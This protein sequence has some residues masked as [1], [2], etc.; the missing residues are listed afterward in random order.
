MTF[1][2]LTI[3]DLAKNSNREETYFTEYANVTLSQATLLFRLATCLTEL[4]QDSNLQELAKN[5]ILELAFKF[6]ET[7][8]HSDS[9]FS[10][11]TSETIG[12][13]TYN[14]SLAKLNSGETLGSPWFDLAVSELG[15]CDV[16]GGTHGTGGIEVFEHDGSFTPGKFKGNSR[17]LGPNDIDENSDFKLWG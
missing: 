16:M 17:L 10:P 6:Y 5:G 8:Q 11:F 9:K 13:Y 7:E 15:V 2:V 4:P 3:A 1:P 12:S 14:I